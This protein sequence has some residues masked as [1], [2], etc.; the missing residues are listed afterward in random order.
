MVAAA[1][2]RDTGTRFDPPSSFCIPVQG[3]LCNQLA[4]DPIERDRRQDQS[5]ASFTLEDYHDGFDFGVF[6]NRRQ[7]STR[8][9]MPA[10]EAA[11]GAKA[12]AAGVVFGSRIAAMQPT[13]Y[14]IPHGRLPANNPSSRK[15]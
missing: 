7:E 3:Q 8:A 4:I 6:M 13:R 5:A 14:P 10:A 12:A 9:N 15:E 11:G 2:S 1:R